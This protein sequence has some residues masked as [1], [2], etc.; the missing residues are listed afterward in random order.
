MS[1][2]K[3]L[4]EMDELEEQEILTEQDPVQLALEQFFADGLITEVLYVVKSG[5]EATVYCCQA[6]PSTGVEL[7]AAKIYRS[8]NNRGFKND[9]VYQE[10]RLI[11]DGHVRRAVQNKSRFGREAQFSMWIDYEFTALNAL[12]KAGADI[13]RPFARSDS[14]LLMEYLGDRQQAAPSLQGVELA[15]NE[16]YP[17]FERLM[18]NIELWLANN[19]IHAD[20][21]AYNVLYWQGQARII[22]FPQAVDPRFNPNARTLLERDI[23]NICRYIAR[24]GL[25][26]DSHAIAD[27]LWRKFKNSEL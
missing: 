20:L 27:R 5:K 16:V 14:A 8:R 2:R 19:Y 7:L 25:Q 23:D 21:S 24:Y 4:R 15:R 9:A 22:D 13:P 12:Y 6:H 1:K 3:L 11:L 17:V 26:R 10:G 18:R